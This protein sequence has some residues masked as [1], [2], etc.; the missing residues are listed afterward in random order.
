MGPEQR[1]YPLHLAGRLSVVRDDQVLNGSAV[2]KAWTSSQSSTHQIQDH[3][4]ESETEPRVRV[5]HQREG[6]DQ[7]Q[8]VARVS[9]RSSLKQ[10]SGLRSEGVGE[11]GERVIQHL[12]MW[13]VST[14]SFNPRWTYL[15][16]V[17][18]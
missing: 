14:G 8:S 9:L 15:W 2:E 3:R 5:E 6:A 12:D 1:F 11:C 10:P 17:G 7:S 18:G 16:K 13:D 4:D